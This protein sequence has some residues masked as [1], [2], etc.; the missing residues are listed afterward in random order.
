[1]NQNGTFNTL[2]IN[3]SVV[4]EKALL[5]RTFDKTGTQLME[6][7][8]PLEPGKTVLSALTSSLIRDELM[9]AG[10]YGIG[11]SKQASGF[12]SVVADPFG[13]QPVYYHDFPKLGHFLEY[14]NP[15]RSE[16]IKT[17]SE[18]NR[19]HGK[20]PDFRANVTA[21]R[22]EEHQEG[23]YLLAEV[24]SATSTGTTTMYPY[25]SYNG[26]Y[27][28][29]GGYSSGSPYS[30]R[31]YTPPYGTGQ[32][33]ATS[34]KVI[35]STVV[36]FRPDG[37]LDWDH[38]IKVDNDDRAALE[39]ASDFWCDKNSILLVT[40]LES[41]IS[42]KVRFKNDESQSDTV[43]IML[44]NPGDEVRE[45]SKDQGGVRYWYSNKLYTWGYHTLKDPSAEDRIRNVF[46]IV[47][48]DA[49]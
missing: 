28:P 23:F 49:N 40:K 12:F 10:T 6:D 27:S 33:V 3:R 29:Y 14:V 24:Y 18:R 11:G 46:Y 4:A 41:D 5:L 48:V 21:V 25:Q 8:I 32:P 9:I 7:N 37:M 16:K 39:Q 34:V 43:K 13:E 2:V 15:K 31:Y 30:N 35:E 42:T 38:S 45:E 36:V 47:R 19:L 26:Y 44:K 22:L 20:D 1:M 17:V